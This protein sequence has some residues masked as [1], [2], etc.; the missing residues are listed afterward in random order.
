[1]AYCQRR[2][3]KIGIVPA[4]ALDRP[5][6][7]RAVDSQP[8]LATLEAADDHQPSTT[9]ETKTMGTTNI[10]EITEITNKSS[11]TYYMYVWDNAHEGRF[12]PYQKDDWHYPDEGKWLTVS[13]HAHL[14]ADDCGIPDGGKSAGKDRC[15]VLFKAR[16]SEGRK[17]GDPG[18]GL[19]VNRV[20]DGNGQDRLVFANHA[21]G[22]NIGSFA[23][24]TSTHQNLLLLLEDECKLQLI[25]RDEGQSVEGRV[26][27]VFSE[28]GQAAKDVL[29]VAVAI[30]K[31]V[32]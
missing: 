4:Q 6:G 22:E 14:R 9:H 17:Q 20:G 3:C 28:I 18:R 10:S 19:R 1:M 32:G 13:P 11:D 16:G 5:C 2:A 15:R 24:K 21:T 25:V 12:T 23:V 31:A 29:K 26:K 27:E 7:R 30:A 8:S